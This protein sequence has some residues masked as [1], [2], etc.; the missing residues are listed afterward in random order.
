MIIVICIVYYCIISYYIRYKENILIGI[1]S[2]MVI[3]KLVISIN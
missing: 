1:M 2:V 3:S